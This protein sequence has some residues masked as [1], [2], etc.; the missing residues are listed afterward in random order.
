MRFQFTALSAIALLL[1]GADARI[2]GFK[3][4]K[5]IKPGDKFTIAAQ[6]T[7]IAATNP[8]A[9]IEVQADFGYAPVSSASQGSIGTFLITLLWSDGTYIY[10][11]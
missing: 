10:S 1:S 7:T 2:M 3:M 6:G 4:P 9:D 8:P 11:A 5:T